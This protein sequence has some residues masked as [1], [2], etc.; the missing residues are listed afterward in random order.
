[1]SSWATVT[2][3]TTRVTPCSS[4]SLA[5]VPAIN[6]ESSRWRGARGGRAGISDVCCAMLT[7]CIACTAQRLAAILLFHT[8]DLHTHRRRSDTGTRAAAASS[9]SMPTLVSEKRRVSTTFLAKGGIVLEQ[10]A[11]SRR[12]LA[13]IRSLIHEQVLIV[14]GRASDGLAGVVDDDVEPCEAVFHMC[15]KPL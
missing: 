3:T 6:C 2:P 12:T 14:L 4:F 9:S 13:G 15:T 10:R 11:H 7:P 5:I 1:V 8:Q